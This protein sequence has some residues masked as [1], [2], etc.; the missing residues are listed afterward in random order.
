[1][2]ALVGAR[3]AHFVPEYKPLC[4]SKTSTMLVV[5]NPFKKFRKKLEELKLVCSWLEV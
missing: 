3:L 5:H 1:M 2:A 4:R